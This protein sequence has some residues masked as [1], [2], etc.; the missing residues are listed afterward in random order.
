MKQLCDLI[1]LLETVV[2]WLYCALCACW[3]QR[4]FLKEGGW[5]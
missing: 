4:L 3:L 2:R 5:L 1:E